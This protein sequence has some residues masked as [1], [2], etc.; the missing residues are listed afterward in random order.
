M[1]LLVIGIGGCGGNTVNNI[2]R[3]GVENVDFVLVDNDEKALERAAT[4]KKLLIEKDDPALEGELQKL[5]SDSPCVVVVA[6]MGGKYS[7]EV[8]AAL[9][10][11]HKR[12]YADDGFVW[13]FAVMPFDFERRDVRAAENLAKV[14]EV[15]TRVITFDNN[16]LRQYNDKPMNEAFAVVDQSVCE[17]VEK[18]LGLS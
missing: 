8:V 6:G 1:K 13:V 14:N 11:T 7:S 5:L 16:T 18:A 3:K 9:C 10:R 2:Y 17:V 12:I 4:V 15:A